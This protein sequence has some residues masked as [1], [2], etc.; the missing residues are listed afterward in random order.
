[1]DRVTTVSVNTVCMASAGCVAPGVV[2]PEVVAPAVV[3]PA[4]VA[5]AVVTT[6]T[7]AIVPALV[8][9]TENFISDE[10][11]NDI[12]DVYRQVKDDVWVQISEAEEYPLPPSFS[13][14]F[15]FLHKEAGIIWILFFYLICY[16]NYF[17]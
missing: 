6:A 1:M 9:F 4:A 3:A 17:L 8:R 15:S 7:T 10:V 13:E 2:A 14:R 16:F 11:L 5:P 12:L